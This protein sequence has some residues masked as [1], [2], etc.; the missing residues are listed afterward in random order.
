MSEPSRRDSDAGERSPAPYPPSELT[1]DVVSE[2]GGVD[3]CTLY[4][5]D[6][7]EETVLTHWLSAEAPDFVD[8][9]EMR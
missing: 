1:A 7:D 8:C 9:E 6:A 5:R 4:P 3:Y 2:S